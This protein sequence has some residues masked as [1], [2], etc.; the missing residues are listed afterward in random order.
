MKT[1]LFSGAFNPIGK[2]HMKMVNETLKHVNKVIIMPVYKSMSAKVLVSGNH[3]LNMCK[4][5]VRNNED[6]NVSVSDFEIKYKID[7][8]PINIIKKFI[9]ETNIKID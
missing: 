8:S 2:H 7:N 9:N 3:R 1:A 4:L 5:A 6:N